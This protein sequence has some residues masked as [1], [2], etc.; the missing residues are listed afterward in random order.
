MVRSLCVP[1]TPKRA[2][3]EL[4]LGCEWML[5]TLQEVPAVYGSRTSAF[6]NR[7]SRPLKLPSPI[8]INFSWNI[9]LRS[10][11]C[12]VQQDT[13]KGGASS[14]ILVKSPLRYIRP[15]L[16]PEINDPAS[17]IRV[18]GQGRVCRSGPSLADHSKRNARYYTD[19]ALGIPARLLALALVRGKCMSHSKHLGRMNRAC[20]T[21]SPTA[22]CPAGDTQPRPAAP[23][24][25]RTTST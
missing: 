16:R 17:T 10:R 25:T 23:P 8:R 15:N 24:Q 12:G 4:R 2:T 5:A 21:S 13:H 9:S 20:L 3:I 18:L 11:E 19:S 14:R 7:G 1:D 6:V 22:G